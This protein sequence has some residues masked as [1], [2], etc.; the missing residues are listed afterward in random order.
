MKERPS[1]RVDELYKPLIE[2]RRRARHASGDLL[3]RVDIVDCLQRATMA[4]LD[5]RW[6]RSQ[7]RGRK[8]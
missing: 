5:E 4:Y 6:E 7:R 1:E 2:E 3:D 8:P